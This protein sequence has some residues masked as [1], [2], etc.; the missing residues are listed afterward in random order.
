MTSQPKIALKTA[1]GRIRMRF[2]LE[3]VA[4]TLH[5]LLKIVCQQRQT[6]EVVKTLCELKKSQK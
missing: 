2:L 6:E 1:S 5:Y 3:N 4:E